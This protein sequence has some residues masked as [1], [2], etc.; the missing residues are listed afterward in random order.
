MYMYMFTYIYIYVS[1]CVCDFILHVCEGIIH[2]Y[3]IANVTRA[4]QAP[5]AAAGMSVS[6]YSERGRQVTN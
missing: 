6:L 2:I 5:R 4:R 3:C 1:L